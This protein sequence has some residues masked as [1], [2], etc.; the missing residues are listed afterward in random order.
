M[1][2]VY[3]LYGPKYIDKMKELFVG[4]VKILSGCGSGRC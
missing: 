4:V 3:R 1:S 2:I